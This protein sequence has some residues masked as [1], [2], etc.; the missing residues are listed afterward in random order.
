MSTPISL[1][2]ALEARFLMDQFWIREKKKIIS[3][4]LN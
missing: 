4:V 1:M 3:S 2:L